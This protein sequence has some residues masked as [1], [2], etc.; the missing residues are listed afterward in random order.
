MFYF[1]QALKDAVSVQQ[2]QGLLN[3]HTNAWQSYWN[4]GFSISDSKAKGAINGHKIN[5]TI[6]YV[7]SQIPRGIANVEKSIANNE[8][9]YRGHHTL[10]V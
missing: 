9:C 7:L 1:T 10:L 5:S 6:Y 3:Q 2:Q 8:G 4:T